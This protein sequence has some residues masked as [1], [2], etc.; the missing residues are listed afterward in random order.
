MS[1]LSIR[2]KIGAV[3]A[4]IVLSFVVAFILI[5]RDVNRSDHQLTAMSAISERA[6]GQVMPLGDRI[7]AVR[8][9][10]VQVQQWLTD[11]SATQG[12]DGLD[13]GLQK[14]AEYAARFETDTL[15]ARRLATALGLDEVVGG[16]DAVRT[17]FTPFYAGGRRM[18]DAYIA[19]G[20]EK[21]NLV[22]KELDENA[23]ALDEAVKALTRFVDKETEEQTARLRSAV[24]ESHRLSE[25]IKLTV[26]AAFVVVLVVAGLVV[27]L[28]QVQVVAP[29]R[30]IGG[31]MG[32]LA[33]GDLS[34]EVG[35]HG[36]RDEIGTMAEALRVFRASA[37]DNERLRAEQEGLRERGIK[38]RRQ[39]LETMAQTV[40]RETRAA[41]EQVADRTHQMNRNAQAMSHSAEAVSE[42]AQ[43]VAAS[44]QQALGNAQTVAAATEQ[45]TASIGEISQR[46][47]HASTINRKAVTAAESATGTIQSLTQAVD[48]IGEV[49]G[50][51][52]GIAA[53][54]NLLALNATI[55]AARAGDA[56]KGFAVVASE[57]KNL[58]NQ[59]SNSTEEIARQIGEIQNV[60]G[61]A[62]RAVEEIVRTIHEMD[63]ISTSIA[64]AIE[65]QAAA[66]SEISRTVGETSQAAQAVADSITRVSAEADSTGSRARDV[67]TV[68]GDMA[69]NI[70][71]LREVLVRIV[72]TSTSDV[73][74]RRKPRYALDVGCR[75]NDQPG[76]IGNLSEGGATVEGMPASIAAGQMVSV[77]I[78]G[79]SM[80][81]PARVLSNTQGRLHVK[82]E[83]SGAVEADF[84][85]A[86]AALVRGRTPIGTAA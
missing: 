78:D 44:A 29:L 33:Q 21:G 71:S 30:R 43:A 76:R 63:Q 72:R 58:S 47:T 86:F 84:A 49:A 67:Q 56:G 39:A 19:G 64:T 69:S 50:L 35:F 15:E 16:I 65:E 66:T 2:T 11:V 9:D 68:A 73:D 23:E 24:A 38:E 22:M 1:S 34:V 7:D 32:V 8:Y 5:L 20:P 12:K 55:E 41:V 3:L 40:E 6:L 37:R 18:A 13:D 17:A 79:V 61:A 83:A 31:V 51:I 10:V 52:N 82:F 36:R 48:R 27:V 75:V 74:R 81:L 54:T 45:L 77:R 60:T 57:V 80:T 53:Q 14:A 4:L 59:T 26:E 46:V 42:N 25:G 28:V 70:D 62:V 85:R